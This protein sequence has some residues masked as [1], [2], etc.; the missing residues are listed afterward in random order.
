[1]TSQWTNGGNVWLPNYALTPCLPMR[2]VT[3][4]KLYPQP[5][6]RFNSS[7]QRK[8]ARFEPAWRAIFVRERQPKSK[9]P[10]TA[11]SSMVSVGP[12][13]GPSPHVRGLLDP[14]A[15]M[16]PPQVGLKHSGQQLGPC[17]TMTSALTCTPVLTTLNLRQLA[18]A[19][20][21]LRAIR[22]GGRQYPVVTHQ[23]ESRRRHEGGQ[24]FQQLL[25]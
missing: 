13:T 9:A 8:N 15:L 24:F 18:T 11:S 16:W 4:L 5:Y 3:F 19:E 14:L 25:R 17:D 1:M 20:H 10:T 7:L 22:A 21:D 2:V 12:I 6:P 23:I